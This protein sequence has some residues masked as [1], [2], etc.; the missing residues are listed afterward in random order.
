[1][2]DFVERIFVVI[3]TNTGKT[4]RNADERRIG[5]EI[6][7]IDSNSGVVGRH[8]YLGIRTFEGTQKGRVGARQWSKSLQG[9]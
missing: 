2:G 6:T 1:M 4:R 5:D 7:D 9:D 3:K 8:I